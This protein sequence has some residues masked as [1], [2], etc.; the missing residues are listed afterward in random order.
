MHHPIH[1]F[2]S[3]TFR[4]WL[5][6]KARTGLRKAWT[7]HY[8]ILERQQ[9]RCYKNDQPDSQPISTF[10]LREYQLQ[11]KPSNKPFTFQLIHHTKT[12]S[13]TS[14][15][16]SPNLYLQAQ[17][18]NEWSNWVDTLESHVGDQHYTA[19]FNSDSTVDF[20]HQQQ[21][22][23]QA[24]HYH[25]D[26]QMDVLDKWLERYDLIVPRADRSSPSLLSLAPSSSFANDN[27]DADIDCNGLDLDGLA[28]PA[29]QHQLVNLSTTSSPRFL[30]FLWTV[31]T[32]KI[33]V[34]SSGTSPLG[35]DLF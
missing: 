33:K 9:L 20:L 31:N 11:N 27:N 30:G 29:P 23:Q 16:P 26:Q 25:D 17:D 2:T 7:R 14:R 18:E 6:K 19:E 15:T 22:Q 12:T 28:L 3:P 34:P 5:L 8:F 32:K 35:S 10:D 13:S 4:G 24:Y 21:Q 1:S